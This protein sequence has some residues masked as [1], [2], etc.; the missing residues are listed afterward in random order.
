MEF[1]IFPKKYVAK[2]L[3]SISFFSDPC[4]NI[5]IG[6]NLY[7]IKNLHS[8]EYQNVRLEIHKVFLLYFLYAMMPCLENWL[9]YEDETR[10]GAIV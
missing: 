1:N 3:R 10:D 6:T 9:F 5:I 7:S 2:P 8:S 4:E